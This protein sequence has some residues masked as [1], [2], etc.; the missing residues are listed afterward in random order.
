MKAL[1]AVYEDWG[2]G[3]DG[4]QPLVIPADRKFFREITGNSPIIVG[5][6]TL[7]DFPGGRPLKNRPNIVL[8]RQNI[9]IEGA[10]VVH[11]V[12]EALEAVKD[13]G[14][15]VF[16]VGGESVF[17]AMLPY[18]KRAYVTK[19]AANPGSDV[20]FPNLDQDPEWKC[21][22][23]GQELDYEGIKYR[24]CIYDRVK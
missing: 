11:S 9:E 8:T 7:E 3:R 21:T 4:T 2:I 5:R 20:F 10:T 23:P 24:F 6:R 22:D 1:V 18:C 19:I 13:W 15:D 14:D 17:N 16:V 12:E